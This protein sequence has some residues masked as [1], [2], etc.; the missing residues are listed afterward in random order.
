MAIN[1]EIIKLEVEY[2]EL[3][4]KVEYEYTPSTEGVLTGLADE[5]EEPQA[6]VF[7]IHS[8]SLVSD[9]GSEIDVSGLIV[10]LSDSIKDKIREIEE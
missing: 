4:F 5:W 3:D 2:Q 7:D 8:L 1:T 10:P 9:D 6:E